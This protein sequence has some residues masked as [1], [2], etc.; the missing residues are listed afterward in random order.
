MNY[1]Y[2]GAHEDGS[3]RIGLQHACVGLARS[4]Q[5]MAMPPASRSLRWA[6]CAGGRTL[7]ECALGGIIYGFGS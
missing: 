5:K 3:R 7:H 4:M 6:H 2:V 1:E